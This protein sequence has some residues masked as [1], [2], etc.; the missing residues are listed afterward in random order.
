MHLAQVSSAAIN[1]SVDT[2]NNVHNVHTGQ[3]DLIQN[4]DVKK[5]ILNTPF[6][7]LSDSGCREIRIGFKRL[8][9]DGH[10]ACSSLWTPTPV[11]GTHAQPIIQNTEPKPK[12]I[13]LRNN[14]TKD[15]TAL[16]KIV[17]KIVIDLWHADFEETTA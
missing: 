1:V 7:L 14:L 12:K 8:K 2:H 10:H 6:A 11:G 4:K 3:L 13:P 5:S 16:K 15:Q 17:V 9:H